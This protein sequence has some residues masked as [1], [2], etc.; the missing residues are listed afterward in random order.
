LEHDIRHDLSAE[1]AQRVA[2]KALESYATR[3]AAYQPSVQWRTDTEAAVE[4]TVKGMHLK[5]GLKIGS[6]RF[7]LNLDVP[8]LLRPLKGRAFAVIE[9]EV[10]GWIAKA[11]SGEA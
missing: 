11:K 3:F 4:F 2:R 1:Q 8:F 5:G 9:R 7:S 10:Q 6:D